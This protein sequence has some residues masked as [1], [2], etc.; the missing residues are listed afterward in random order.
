M[1]RGTGTAVL[2]EAEASFRHF[3]RDPVE[4]D[5]HP[6]RWTQP[7]IPLRKKRGAVYFIG[8][9][10][11]G[12]VKIGFSEA[13]EVGLA[14]LQCGSPVDLVLLAT[15][16]GTEDDERELHKRFAACR[17][18]GEWFERTAEI[19]AEIARLNSGDSR[20]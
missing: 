3:L 8:C 11:V 17:L 2:E 9:K 10:E 14:H 20:G 15:M 18:H 6:R 19:E 12:R 5:R 1:L 4:F 16:P 7:M 13:A